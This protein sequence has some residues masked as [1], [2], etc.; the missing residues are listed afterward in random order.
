MYFEQN[1]R[2]LIHTPESKEMWSSGLN[3]SL[4]SLSSPSTREGGHILFQE[5]GLVTLGKSDWEQVT[6]FYDP[7]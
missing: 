1:Y 3:D 5:Q 7:K 2:N 6:R 4:N